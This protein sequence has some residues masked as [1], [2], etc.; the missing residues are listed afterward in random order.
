MVAVQSEEKI[1]ALTL[2][3]NLKPKDERTIS[4][5]AF[6][7]QIR[8]QLRQILVKLRGVALVGSAQRPLAP[9]NGFAIALFNF[10]C[11]FLQC[12]SRLSIPRFPH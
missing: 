1:N 2:Y 4:Q 7:L 6:E 3:I 9:C 8:P 12:L 10:L 11:R 5:K